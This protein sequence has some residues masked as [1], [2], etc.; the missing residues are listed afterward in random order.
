MKPEV[1]PDP[2]EA[3][4]K[5]K[6]NALIKAL[7]SLL[8]IL[9]VAIL[10]ALCEA[11]PEFPASNYAVRKMITGWINPL[12]IFIGGAGFYRCLSIWDRLRKSDPPTQYD[13]PLPE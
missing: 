7:A 8:F 5:A 9:A 2:Y 10:I 3:M 1:T 4:R 13:E 11:D 6:R 12:F